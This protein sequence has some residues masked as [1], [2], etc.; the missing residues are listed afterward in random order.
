[1]VRQMRN[2]LS[3]L[4]AFFRLAV[5]DTSKLTKPDLSPLGRA[6]TVDELLYG[7]GPGR[8]RRRLRRPLPGVAGRV[9]TFLRLLVGDTSTVVPPDL[10]PLGRAATVDELLH[11][12]KRGD[13]TRTRDPESSS[14]ERG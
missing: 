3:A 8:R 6:P 9:K 10:T 5:G 11:G 13:A 14:D 12:L 1:M 4:E 7:R 2:L